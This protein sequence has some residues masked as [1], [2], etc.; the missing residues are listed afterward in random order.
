MKHETLPFTVKPVIDRKQLDRVVD[1]RFNAYS[2]HLP[3]FAEMLKRPELM[4]DNNSAVVLIAESK[5]DGSVL[6]TIRIHTNEDNPLPLENSVQLPDN[7]YGRRLVEATR[8]AVTNAKGGSLVTT[9]LFKA[10]F[11]FC[12]ATAVDAIVVAG[13]SPVDRIYKRLMFEDVFPDGVFVELKH[14]GNLPHRIMSFPIEAAY[15]RWQSKGHPLFEYFANTKHPDLEFE[16][17]GAHLI[18]QYEA[19]MFTKLQEHVGEWKKS[20]EINYQRIE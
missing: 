17:A 13:R 5:L 12:K 11:G 7:F 18:S 4:D 16:I 1:M 9:A 14:A 8:L 10:L 19:N 15:D 20:Q 2:R 6:G 3:A